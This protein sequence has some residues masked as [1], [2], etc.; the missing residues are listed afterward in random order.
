MTFEETDTVFNDPRVVYLES[1]P[2]HE[3]RLAGIGLSHQ[4]EKPEQRTSSIHEGQFNRWPACSNTRGT[5]RLHA[6][7]VIAAGVYTAPPS[8]ARTPMT[9]GDPL[10]CPAVEF[11][12]LMR[13]R[14]H[15]LGPWEVA[16]VRFDLGDGRSTSGTLR[17]G[18][19]R[20][21]A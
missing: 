10:A 2:P 16:V 4:K 13:Q 12:A 11:R 7:A 20:G 3:I 15:R 17:A 19:P 21:G 5:A 18:A 6:G 8:R 14:G 9:T 1:G